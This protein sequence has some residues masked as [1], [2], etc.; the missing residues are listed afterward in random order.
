[1]IC[2]RKLLLTFMMVVLQCCGDRVGSGSMY[3]SVL[4]VAG[5]RCY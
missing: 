4:R 2:A 5:W 1:M 3:F